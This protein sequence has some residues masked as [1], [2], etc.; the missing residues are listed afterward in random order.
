MSEELT[1]AFLD[2]YNPTTRELSQVVGFLFE[3]EIN[4]NNI[5]KENQ[6]FCGF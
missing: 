6:D 1:V 4:L 2:Q 3:P 5:I